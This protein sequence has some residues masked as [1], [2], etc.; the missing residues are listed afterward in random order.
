MV[1]YLLSLQGCFKIRRLFGYLSIEHSNKLKFQFLYLF[2][3]N[4][5]T[6][7]NNIL[8]RIR[9][10]QVTVQIG[11]INTDIGLGERIKF[12]RDEHHV[13]IDMNVRGVKYDFSQQFTTFSGEAIV[14]VISSNE[15]YG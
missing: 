13:D 12:A 1:I 8:T 5:K 3:G 6:I 11:G 14:N 15:L 4:Q 7:L 10:P 9:K 2:L